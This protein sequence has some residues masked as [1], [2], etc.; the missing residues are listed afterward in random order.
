M[1][2]V[3]Y[4]SS[5]MN[6]N[7]THKA[8][9]QTI[10]DRWLYAPVSLAPNLFNVVYLFYSSCYQLR[11]I[12]RSHSDSKLRKS[13]SSR[14]TSFYLPRL[15]HVTGTFKGII[16]IRLASVK[17]STMSGINLRTYRSLKRA[18]KIKRRRGAK[19]PVTFHHQGHC[20]FRSVLRLTYEHTLWHMTYSYW[21]M[22]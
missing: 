17:N 8:C 6:W 13:R 4:R 7:L 9:S 22:T 3:E 5:T 19:F 10:A 18:G 20:I 15:E 2:Q 21:R 1:P 14:R 16:D 11:K 12:K